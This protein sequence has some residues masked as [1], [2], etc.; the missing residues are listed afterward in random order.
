MEMESEGYTL[1]SFNLV[2]VNTQIPYY[3]PSKAPYMPDFVT[4]PLNLFHSMMDQVR[5]VLGSERL[6]C[7]M[8]GNNELHGINLHRV[9]HDADVLVKCRGGFNTLV[10]P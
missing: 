6:A 3:L 8:N 4:N 7:Q 1:H 2:K 10:H 5:I 9:I